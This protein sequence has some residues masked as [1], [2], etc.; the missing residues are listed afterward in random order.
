MYLAPR[1][2]VNLSSDQKRVCSLMELLTSFKGFIFIPLFSLTKLFRPNKG[3]TFT[4]FKFSDSLKGLTF[5]S[6]KLINPVAL[7]SFCNLFLA[8]SRSHFYG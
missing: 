3:F 2:Q 5:K 4:P 8:I 7:T 1:L 6:F